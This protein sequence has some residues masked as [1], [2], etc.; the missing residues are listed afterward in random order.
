MGD[1]VRR[2]ATMTRE[3]ERRRADTAAGGR[4]PPT[5]GWLRGRAPRSLSSDDQLIATRAA[6]V[7]V[8]G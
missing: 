2:R 4:L 1:D 5:D 3:R 6:I 8:S 7:T